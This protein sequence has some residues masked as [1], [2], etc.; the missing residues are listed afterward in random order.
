MT[1]TLLLGTQSGDLTVKATT[2]RKEARKQLWE[3]E[4]IANIAQE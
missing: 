1:K 2:K 3:E 4:N